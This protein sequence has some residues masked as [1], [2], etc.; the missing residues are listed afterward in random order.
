[1]A[2]SVGPNLQHSC[3]LLR[4]KTFAF[5]VEFHFCRENIYENCYSALRSTFNLCFVE[6]SFTNR[7]LTSQNLLKLSTSKVSHYTVFISFQP[8]FPSN[9]TDEGAVAGM[10][11]EFLVKTNF[12]CV[13]SSTYDVC[14]CVACL[15]SPLLGN[16]NK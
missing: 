12:V 11:K 9:Q 4:G 10:F 2:V 14:V 13:Y 5:W 15:F 3:K 6:K 7:S 8:C 16:V 1:V